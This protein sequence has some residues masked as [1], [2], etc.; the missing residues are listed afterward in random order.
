MEIIPLPL[1]CVCRLSK[2]LTVS[3]LPKP[4][5]LILCLRNLI[6]LYTFCSCHKF[7]YTKYCNYTH[8]LSSGGNIY[9]TYFKFPLFVCLNFTTFI[10]RIKISPSTIILLLLPY[11]AFQFATN[12]KINWIIL[13]KRFFACFHRV[14]GKLQ[15]KCLREKS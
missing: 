2:A 14:E 5:F 9:F 11:F 15:S 1:K 3:I 4:F 6:F 8:E 13:Q 10:H 12:K 7:L